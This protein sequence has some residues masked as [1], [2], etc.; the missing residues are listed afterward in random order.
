MNVIGLILVLVVSSHTE[1]QTFTQDAL[2]SIANGLKV[3]W[4]VRTNTKEVERFEAEVTLENGASTEVLSYGPWK[5][6]FFCIFM[7]EPDL[8]GNRGNK[9]AELVGQGVKVTHVQG[10]FFYLEPTESFLPLPPGSVRTI[11]IKVRFWSV[12]RTDAMHNWYIEYPGLEPV[13]IASTQG[14]DLAFV[15][16]RTS[17]AQWKR[18]DF[19]EYNPFTAQ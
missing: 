2:N 4:T 10:S 3:K 11:I 18:Y 14:E 7:I 17:P 13:V 6:Y 12:A 1:A 19:D 8:L 16:E 5:I 9:G 15:S